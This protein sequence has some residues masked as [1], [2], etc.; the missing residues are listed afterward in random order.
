MK[1]ILL[2]AHNDI[3][4]FLRDKVSWFWLIVVPIMFS[5]FMGFAAR[6]PGKPQDPRPKVLI[7]NRDEGF[8]GDLL[9]AEL[10]AQDLFVLSE[11]Q[12]EEAERGLRI[13]ENFTATVQEKEQARVEFFTVNESRDP[14]AAMVELRLWRALI[15]VNAAIVG[16]ALDAGDEAIRDEAALRL[17]LE[18]P[19]PVQV[20]AKFA[21][22]RP[23]PVKFNQSLPGNLVMM[24]ML[25]LL[26]FGGTTLAGERQGGMLRRLVVHPIRRHELVWGK[27]YGRFL[28]GLV[29]SAVMLLF[30]A[31]VMKVPVFRDPLGMLLIVAAY[32]WTCAS[33]GVLI[34]A[35][36]K[37]PDKIT[38]LCILAAL[39]MAALGGCWWPMEIAPQWLQTAAHFVPA[40]W[41]MDGFHQLISFGG[42]FRDIGIELLALVGFAVAGSLAAGRLLRY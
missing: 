8:M 10:Q 29:Q 32:C 25:N 7:E 41:A 16:R 6:G 19:N 13:P 37:N 23:V 22:R 27:I 12:A 9:V 14:S 5:F 20:D 26:I 39:L 28:L 18:Q 33:F 15:A 21:G 11:D 3:R 17:V 42:T 24:V 36:A 35:T 31:F 30:G 40:G 4:M 1:Q 2:I 38:G 34:G